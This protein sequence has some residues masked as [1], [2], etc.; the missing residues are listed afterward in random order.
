MPDAVR[1]TL[2]AD[3]MLEITLAAPEH[4]NAL[5]LSRFDKHSFDAVLLM[6]PLY[7]LLSADERLEVRDEADL[8]ERL[9][10]NVDGLV[11]E[12]GHHR[13]TFLPQV[14]E[15]LPEKRRFLEELMRKAEIPADTRLARCKLWRY[16]VIK[17]QQPALH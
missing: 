10:P 7:H 8:L 3:D 14:W 2:A 1:V 4:G 16:R 5:D 17:W 6:G 15:G 9:R 13:A 12:C 11:L